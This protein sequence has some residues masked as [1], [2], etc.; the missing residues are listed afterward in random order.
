[1]Y[2]KTATTAIQEIAA[3]QLIEKLLEIGCIKEMKT[4]WGRRGALKLFPLYSP[5][6]QKQI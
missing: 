4:T 3:A 5:Y 6:P 1:M 2:W